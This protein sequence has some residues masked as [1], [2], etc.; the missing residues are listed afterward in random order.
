[1]KHTFSTVHNYCVIQVTKNQNCCR[2][3]V[4]TFKNS[5]TIISIK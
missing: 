5:F 4:C 3:E 2:I 1:M